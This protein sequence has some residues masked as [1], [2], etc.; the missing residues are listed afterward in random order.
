MCHG[1]LAG[2]TAQAGQKQKWNT[3]GLMKNKVDRNCTKGTGHP[4]GVRITEES[5][6]KKTE[7]L[8]TEV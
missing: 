7:I 4:T 5:N 2:T 1:C 8:N 6:K 3:K